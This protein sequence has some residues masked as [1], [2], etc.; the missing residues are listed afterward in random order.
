MRGLLA[1]ILLLPLP[2]WAQEAPAPSY[3]ILGRCTFND[4]LSVSVLRWTT[5]PLAGNMDVIADSNPKSA[6]ENGWQVLSWATADSAVRFVDI[7]MF[8]GIGKILITL[9]ARATPARA[10]ATLTRLYPEGAVLT[11]PGNCES[12]KR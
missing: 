10:Y 4:G 9:D 3:E 5:G 2:A 11:A 8:S 6:L 1:A 7:R 12:T